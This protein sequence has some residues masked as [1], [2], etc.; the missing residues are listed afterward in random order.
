MWDGLSLY[1]VSFKIMYGGSLMLEW[2]ELCM[3]EKDI[4]CT[5]IVGVVLEFVC[6]R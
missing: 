1:I 2:C 6:Y 3:L 4:V 5:V